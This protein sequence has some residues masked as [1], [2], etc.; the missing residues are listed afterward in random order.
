MTETIVRSKGKKAGDDP[1]AALADATV[2]IRVTV[3]DDTGTE[4]TDISVLPAFDL[5]GDG[6]DGPV[7]LPV[8][9]CKRTQELTA[10]LQGFIDNLSCFD[11]ETGAF[12]SDCDALYD[13]E[14]GLMLKTMNA[15]SFNFI[16]ENLD[17][18]TYVIQAEAEID[19]CLDE[20]VEPACS[21]TA[22]SESHSAAFI[23]LGSMVLNEVRLGN[24]VKNN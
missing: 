1:D 15:N 11:P 13:E 3:Y 23:G 5:P 24:N 18:G 17:A 8:T 4:L 9:Y 19:T 12:Q 10:A 20:F 22:G 6:V 14:I 21:A 2:K 7:N 16:V